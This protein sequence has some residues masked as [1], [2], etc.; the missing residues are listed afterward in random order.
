MEP[1]HPASCA[2]L[3]RGAGLPAALLV[4]IA[5]LFSPG[6][7][8]ADISAPERAALLDLYASTDGDHWV[9][10]AGWGGAAG[11]ECAWFGITCSADG[12]SVEQLWMTNNNM[13]GTLPAS[14]QD[15]VHLKLLFFGNNLLHGP[16]PSLAGMTGLQNFGIGSNAMDGPIP[17]IGNLSQLGLF[18]VGNN[19]LTGPIPDLSGMT[20]LY[21]FDASDNH[22]DGGIPELSTLAA[23]TSFNVS[24]NNLSGTLP[25]LDGL[26]Q[27]ESFYVSDNALSGFP[28]AVPDPN[29][30]VNG[31]S[32]LCPN[33]LFAT[34]SPEW[35][36][37]TGSSPWYQDCS[38]DVIFRDGFDP[39]A[40]Q[41]A[42]PPD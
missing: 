28:P 11:T 42:M 20:S 13:N 4:V 23:L 24:D 39:P 30:L 9:N 40:T 15:L 38:N 33:F 29:A 19:D 26:N 6:P 16:I 8:M 31:A 36:A 35:D 27:L 34:T 18:D 7:V 1:T 17:D 32:R 25:S 21:Q 22:L 5:F 41:A 10:N 3:M 2:R 14:L 12:N 37:A